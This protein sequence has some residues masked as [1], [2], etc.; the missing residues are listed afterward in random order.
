MQPAGSTLTTWPGLLGAANE[1][2]PNHPLRA[3]AEGAR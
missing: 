1:S 2:L 3:P